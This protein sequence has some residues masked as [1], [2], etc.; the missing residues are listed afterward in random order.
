MDRRR[1]GV[2]C[3]VAIAL[4]LASCGPG[5]QGEEI[6]G[7]TPAE[8]D[9]ADPRHM[10]VW[11]SATPAAASDRT[12]HV[13]CDGGDCVDVLLQRGL[14]FCQSSVTPNDFQVL[15][16][17][18]ELPESVVQSVHLGRA[19]GVVAG[20]EWNN[21][22]GTACGNVTAGS[23][24][25]DT[26]T[27]RLNRLAIDDGEELSNLR[28]QVRV[29]T[30]ANPLLVV[31][32]TSDGSTGATTVGQPRQLRSQQTLATFTLMRESEEGEPLIESNAFRVGASLRTGACLQSIGSCSGETSYLPP[33]GEHTIALV[34]SDGLT[35]DGGGMRLGSYLQYGGELYAGPFNTGVNTDS[36]AGV[37]FAV[38]HTTD[39]QGG[40]TIRLAPRTSCVDGDCT[41]DPHLPLATHVPLLEVTKDATLF[42]L[43]DPSRLLVG[44]STQSATGRT[45]RPGADG[46][47][48]SFTVSPVVFERNSYMISSGNTVTFAGS[49]ADPDIDRIEIGFSADHTLAS[50]PVVPVSGGGTFTISRRFDFEWGDSRF[51]EVR[52]YWGSQFVGY[53]RVPFELDGPREDSDGD[54]VADTLDNCPGTHN[55]N[56]VDLNDATAAGYGC[57]TDSDGDGLDD[58]AEDEAGTKSLLRDTDGDGLDDGVERVARGLGL[59]LSGTSA[60][61]DGDGVL[62]GAEFTDSNGDGI[63]NALDPD[64]T[65]VGVD[66]STGLFLVREEWS[67]TFD[68]TVP[69]PNG[70][71][72]LVSANVSFTL[73]YLLAENSGANWLS[74]DSV[75]AALSRNQDHA[76]LTM[77]RADSIGL[78]FMTDISVETTSCRNSGD[79]NPLHNRECAFLP[80]MR[81][82]LENEIE[83]IQ[84]PSQ[85][86]IS[87]E[88]GER[89]VLDDY[90]V[91]GFDLAD[92]GFP[93]VGDA[94]AVGMEAIDPR[95]GAMAY[96]GGLD[97][98]GRTNGSKP[99]TI[100]NFESLSV[101]SSGGPTQGLSLFLCPRGPVDPVTNVRPLP[102]EG[103]NGCEGIGTGVLKE[104][105]LR[106]SEFNDFRSPNGTADAA[107]YSLC[108]QAVYELVRG[109]GVGA[110]DATI[111]ADSGFGTVVGA[112]NN[113]STRDVRFRT[114][115]HVLANVAAASLPHSSFRRS[116]AATILALGVKFLD[117]KERVVDE[118]AGAAWEAD[119]SSGTDRVLFGRHIS[120][121]RAAMAAT[122]ATAGWN[123]WFRV[124]VGLPVPTTPRARRVMEELMRRCDARADKCPVNLQV[125]LRNVA[126]TPGSLVV[127]QTLSASDGNLIAQNVQLRQLRTDGDNRG[128]RLRWTGQPRSASTLNTLAVSQTTSTPQTNAQLVGCGRTQLTQANNTSDSTLP[129]LDRTNTLIHPGAYQFRGRLARSGGAITGVNCGSA[130]PVGTAPPS[131][132]SPRLE[133]YPV[134][135]ALSVPISEDFTSAWFL[136]QYNTV[137]PGASEAT[138][139]VALAEL[140]SQLEAAFQGLAVDAFS[141]GS[142]VTFGTVLPIVEVDL[143][144]IPGDCSTLGPG[145]GVAT[146][147]RTTAQSLA[148]PRLVHARACVDLQAAFSTLAGEPDRAVCALRA[149]GVG[150]ETMPGG[151]V[152]CTYVWDPVVTPLADTGAGTARRIG[153]AVAI[154]G[155]HELGHGLGLLHSPQLPQAEYGSCGPPVTEPGPCPSIATRVATRTVVARLGSLMHG[156]TVEPQTPTSTTCVGFA[157]VPGRWVERLNA[158]DRLIEGSAAISLFIEPPSTTRGGRVSNSAD[159]T[160]RGVVAS[161][162]YVRRAPAAY[163][164]NQYRTQ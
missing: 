90:P 164:V 102:T 111:R 55:P 78:P 40:G 50:V 87:R 141:V 156:A 58:V 132:D 65:T 61:T 145:E 73:N 96:Y 72:W 64:N 142:A 27:I 75:Q 26:V 37:P 123:D 62:D 113:G 21:A 150:S 106:L 139:N 99:G 136:G 74:T 140:R 68:L 125:Q 105:G 135:S 42:R 92:V 1:R 51:L 147:G 59:R 23:G 70:T 158:G 76:A 46:E 112:C 120:R 3:A 157:G 118:T 103:D 13:A 115:S 151:P 93:G 130:N 110:V 6:A 114:G 153:A 80:G 34:S 31:P 36:Y 100:L 63:S 88:D 122:S 85:V 97:A 146:V 129:A 119:N 33:H 128:V 86:R 94:A 144:S 43:G 91:D 4:A 163:L 18:Q 162:P 54:G 47:P 149:S 117:P 134:F 49:T 83:T 56:Q 2:G 107:D 9:I 53:D 84:R 15:L 77:A 66:P 124:N 127:A 25:F 116:I 154:I 29:P 108:D 138:A 12:S 71:E 95:L 159:L 30:G 104:E 89:F 148:G 101:S 24:L 131:L 45:F 126:A 19:R 57:E 155:I 38:H 17:S 133:S 39:T 67:N 143:T 79:A 11:Q 160:C 152:S 28:I 41:T 48:T 10:N 137:I 32:I 5:S 20:P 98:A 7:S 44:R 35:S 52:A 121:A 109:T 60:D 22:V 81:V 69:G 82:I 16:R 8:G 14:F 161:P